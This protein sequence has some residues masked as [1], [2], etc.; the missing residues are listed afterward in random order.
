[1]F[2]LNQQAWRGP[3]RTVRR[4]EKSHGGL[5]GSSIPCDLAEAFGDGDER[6]V[7]HRGDTRRRKY[8]SCSAEIVRSRGG[9]FLA[10]HRKDGYGLIEGA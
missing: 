8:R 9:R 2:N 4:G 5:P 3:H 7:G 10:G 1:M 6:A